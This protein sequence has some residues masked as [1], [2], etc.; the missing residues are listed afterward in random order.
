MDILNPADFPLAEPASRQSRAWFLDELDI[1]QTEKPYRLRFESPDPS[2]ARTNI[3]NKE[4]SISIRDLRSYTEPLDYDR[5]GFTTMKTQSALTAEDAA[6]EQ[7]VKQI[8]LESL[9]PVLRDFFGTPNVV[10]LEYVVR[11][12]ILRVDLRYVTG[13]NLGTDSETR[14]VFSHFPWRRL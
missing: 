8:Y 13:L 5:N 7:K 11:S 6:D 1:Y 9:K 4:A 10:M 3:K 14:G 12:F 2:I